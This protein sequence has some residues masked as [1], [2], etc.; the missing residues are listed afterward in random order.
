MRPNRF[1]SPRGIPEVYRPG[2]QPS[3]LDTWNQ[4]PLTT[5]LYFLLLAGLVALFLLLVLI[6]SANMTM[7]LSFLRSLRG[8]AQT[9]QV[10]S[11]TAPTLGF[12]VEPGM[13]AVVAQV[14]AELRSGPAD[15]YPSFGLLETGQAIEV[16]G[17][18]PDG[19]WWAVKVPYVEG[20]LAWV[21]ASQVRSRDT[22]G[23]AVLPLP[24]ELA[25]ATEAARDPAIATALLNVNIRSGPGMEFD[26]IGL[27]QEGQ[28]TEIVEID[29]QRLWYAVKV[30]GEINLQGWIS[31]DYVKVQN[32]DGLPVVGQQAGAP[33]LIPL[34]LI[35]IRAGPGQEFE[36]IGS[37]EKGQGA[38]IVG[39]SANGE[40]WAIKFAAGPEGKGWVSA[41]FVKAENAE[42]VPVIK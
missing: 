23:V 16:A 19:F 41:K 3:L 42:G 15:T 1:F 9:P 28:E 2:Y 11:S 10:T 12:K 25:A 36:V 30:P 39:I 6:R 32:A 26:K 37:L 24:A 31:K 14:N 18:S 21:S 38:E 33:V 29:V 17:V 7:S 34:T 13:P 22:Q 40:W 8:E 5:R 27:L 35:N 20:G 4:L